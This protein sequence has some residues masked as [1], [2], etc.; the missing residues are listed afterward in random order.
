MEEKFNLYKERSELG[1]TQE[2][3]AEF[4]DIT[5]E[6]ISMME[7]RKK[8]V[9]RKVI[10]KFNSLK[11]KTFQELERD[12]YHSTASPPVISAEPNKPYHASTLLKR[13]DDLETDVALLKKLILK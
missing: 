7:T 11:S 2:K 5:P 8:P 13:L 1:L 10:K 4:L 12:V 9:S 6:Y 3:L